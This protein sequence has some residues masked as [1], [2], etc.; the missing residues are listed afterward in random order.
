[1][2]PPIAGSKVPST[3]SGAPPVPEKKMKADYESDADTIAIELR[4]VDQADEGREVPG[5]VIHL[6]EGRA[7]AID[8]LTAS[9]DLERKAELAAADAGVDRDTLLLAAKCAIAQPDR[10]VSV[11]YLRG[12]S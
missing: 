4:E 5:A 10:T 7:I 12:Q 8:I 6:L 1:M 3:K 9:E 11:E 2:S